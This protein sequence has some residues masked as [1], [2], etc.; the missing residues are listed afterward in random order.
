MDAYATP[1]KYCTAC[2]AVLDARAEICPTCGVRQHGAPS[3]PERSSG[4]KS[5]TTAA[6][7]AFLLGGLG[8]HKF[9]LGQAGLGVL[10]LLFCWTFIPAIVA[11]IEFIMY[12]TMTDRAFTAKYG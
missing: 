5:R 11:F 1:T 4:E 8:A 2:A 6:L 12:L 9:Y 10:Y 3:H 7:L